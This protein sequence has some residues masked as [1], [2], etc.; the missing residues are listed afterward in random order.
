MF[1]HGAQQDP[2]GSADNGDQ[3]A[4]PADPG[5]EQQQG[6]GLHHHT[7]DQD[8]GGGFHSTHTFPDGHQ[9]QA[10]HVDYDD[11]K[12]KQDSDFGQ[13]EQ[14]AGDDGGDDGNADFADQ[15]EDSDPTAGIAGSYGSKA[16]A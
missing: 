1:F 8:E 2:S 7:I 11:A 16:K 6:D 10:D 14:D 9:D 5:M 3:M 4:P 13:G 15:G 12:A